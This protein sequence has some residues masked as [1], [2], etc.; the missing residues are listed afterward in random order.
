MKQYGLLLGMAMLLT[1]CGGDKTA[2][3]PSDA[4]KASEQMAQQAAQNT[5][6]HRESAPVAQQPDKA[7]LT[8]EAKAAVQAFS[9]ALKGE[10]ESA[11]KTGGPVEALK[12][13]NTKAP[14]ITKTVSS[15]KGLQ[16]SRVSLKNRNPSNA[17]NDWQ[18]DVLKQFETRKAGGEDMANMAYAEVVGNEFR[19]MKAIP[20]GTLCLNCHGT[21]I[22]P[23]ITAKLGELYPQ[24]KATGFQE[25][26]LR[27]A[28]VVVKN[29]AQ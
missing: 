1:A 5:A 24:D 29:L 10:L 22:S 21:Q 26:D 13:C 7:V 6:V 19:F 14:E 23:A 8:E 2:Q 4:P 17:P 3:A 27:G 11:I 18:T 15:E 28:V 20:T 25:G 9:G 16:I 12:V